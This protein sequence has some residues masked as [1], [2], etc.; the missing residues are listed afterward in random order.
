MSNTEQTEQT[1]PSRWEILS[2]ERNARVILCNTADTYVLL[3]IAK[4]A[5][6]GL[7]ALRSRLLISLP[8]EEVIPLIEEY[9]EKVLALHETVKKICKTAKIKYRT[10]RGINQIQGNNGNGNNS[11][12]A[13][14]S[15]SES[16]NNTLN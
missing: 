16:D 7:K 11:V 15:A 8:P 10:P 13:S 9:T 4:S 12:D 2:R 5:D 3:D 1:E 14:V 6:R